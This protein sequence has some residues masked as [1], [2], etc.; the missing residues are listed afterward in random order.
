MTFLVMRLQNK[1]SDRKIIQMVILNN[2][3]LKII[4]SDHSK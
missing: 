2:K 4:S 3:T 1:K